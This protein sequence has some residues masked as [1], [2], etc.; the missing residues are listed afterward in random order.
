[1]PGSVLGGRGKDA[2]VK[3]RWLGVGGFELTVGERVLLVDPFFTRPSLPQVLFQRL[4]PLEGRVSPYVRRCDAVLVTHPHYDHLLD[5]PIVQRLTGCGV[6]GGPNSLSILRLAGVPEGSLHEIRDGMELRLDPFQVDVHPGDHVRIL[7]RLP[8][9]GE[10]PAGLR[11]PLRAMDYR[12]DVCHNFLI[13]SGGIRLL[14]WNGPTMKGAPGADV[15]LL[16]PFFGSHR[17]SQLLD[18]AKPRWAIPIH[19]DDFTRP[20]S[21]P[22]RSVMRLPSLRRPWLRRLKIDRFKRRVEALGKPVH[23]LIPDILKSYDLSEALLLE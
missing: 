22:M 19:W 12:M 8:F 9:A 5:I 18:L 21:R 7:G 20:L 10:L 23:V 13:S 17:Y 2:A 6:Y 16:Q 14:L 4:A 15:L 1:M 3:F 11:P